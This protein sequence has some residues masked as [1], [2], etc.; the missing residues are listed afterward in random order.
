MAVSS[1]EGEYKALANIS[2]QL[3]W[4][5]ELSKNQG[6]RSIMWSDNLS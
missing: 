3:S 4:L 5:I 1:I 6:Y 2:I